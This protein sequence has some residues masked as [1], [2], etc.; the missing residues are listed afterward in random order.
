M[1]KSCHLLLTKLE[2]PYATLYGLSLNLLGCWGREIFTSS[3]FSESKCKL[4]HENR[5]IKTCIPYSSLRLSVT[6][7]SISEVMSLKR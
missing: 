1:F 5:L 7:N 3:N 6:S 2:N 4:M